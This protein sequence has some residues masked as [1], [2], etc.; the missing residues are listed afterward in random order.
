MAESSY[1]RLRSVYPWRS[2]G[3]STI[4][5]LAG[6][7]GH[8]SHQIAYEAPELRFVLADLENAV[9]DAKETCPVELKDRF[10]YRVVDFFEKMTIPADVYFMRMIL[11]FM[12]DEDCVRVVK[13]IVPAMKKGSRIL[14]A[15][16]IIPKCD[17]MPD[18]KHRYVFNQVSSR[19]FTSRVGLRVRAQLTGCDRTGI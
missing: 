4:V 19:F 2:L 6:G 15:D 17:V 16:G 7:N 10:E 18:P 8:I 11:H 5:D 14:V 1:A 9:K 12:S 13:N 3:K